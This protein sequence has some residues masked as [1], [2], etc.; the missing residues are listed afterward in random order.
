MDDEPPKSLPIKEYSDITMYSDTVLGPEETILILDSG[1][2]I[3]CVGKGFQILFYTGEVISMGVA[4]ADVEERNFKIV[5]AA[6]VLS[7]SQLN[8]D[9][10]IILNQAAYIPGDHQYE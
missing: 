3:S 9:F 1:A 6:T 5:S 2:D 10:I 4:M 7:D 8:R